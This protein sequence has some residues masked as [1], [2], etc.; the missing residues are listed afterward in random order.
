M[1]VTLNKAIRKIKA[2]ASAKLDKKESKELDVLL[3]KVITPIED[4]VN[5]NPKGDNKPNGGTETK[6]IK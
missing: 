4:K 2:S 5:E 3:N 1:K 6:I